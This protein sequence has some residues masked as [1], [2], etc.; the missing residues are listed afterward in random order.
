MSINA[1]PPLLRD[2]SSVLPCFQALL[3]L[4]SESGGQ[5]PDTGGASCM[6]PLCMLKHTSRPDAASCRRHAAYQPQLSSWSAQGML[7]RKQ[8]LNLSA[9]N[10]LTSWCT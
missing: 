7:E 10:N 4:W 5:A 3:A 1:P 6:R 9:N 8:D 2:R